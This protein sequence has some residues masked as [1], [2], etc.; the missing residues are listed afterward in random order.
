MM[1]RC[2]RDKRLTLAKGSPAKLVRN[3]LQAFFTDAQLP[4]SCAKGSRSPF[5][6]SKC[7]Q[8]KKGLEEGIAYSHY[9][10]NSTVANC[11]LGAP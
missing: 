5:S 6:F 1:R 11:V 9:V 8:R 10:S 2:V 3:L 4:S 7:N